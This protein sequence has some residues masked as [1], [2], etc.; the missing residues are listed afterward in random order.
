MTS[1]V[2][3]DAIA[4]GEPD[5]RDGFPH[6]AELLEP[7]P[8]LVVDH[9]ST[10]LA[11]GVRSLLTTPGLYD[12]AARSAAA[13]S[14]DLSWASGAVRACRIR[15]SLAGALRLRTDPGKAAG[16]DENEGCR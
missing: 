8:G 13:K 1:G 3:T 6:A 2:V 16:V 12:R 4:A 11:D 14:G 7:G 10:A 15:A 5:M 9:D